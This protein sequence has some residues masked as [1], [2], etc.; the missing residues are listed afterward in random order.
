MDKREAIR[1]F[2]KENMD[3]FKTPAFAESEYREKKHAFFFSRM[4]GAVG[5]PRDTDIARVL[6]DYLVEINYL[7]SETELDRLLTNPFVKEKLINADEYREKIRSAAGGSEIITPA[8]V[9]D[10]AFTKQYRD[11]VVQEVVTQERTKILEGIE[12][13]LFPSVLDQRASEE[14]SVD[15]PKLESD[16]PWW[17]DLSLEADPFPGQEGLLE[18]SEKYINSIVCRTSIFAKYL[19]YFYSSP[20][21]VLKNTIFSEHSV[22]GRRPYSIIFEK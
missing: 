6:V 12:S 1:I 19:D 9:R 10:A 7:R 21:E 11:N 14:P 15:T 20:T 4:R 22:K 13:S 2:I 18:I 17:Q 5:N 8:K 3:L 16:N